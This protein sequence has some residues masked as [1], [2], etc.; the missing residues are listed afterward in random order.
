MRGIKYR[1][2]YFELRALE[3]NCPKQDDKENYHANECRPL[4]VYS[5]AKQFPISKVSL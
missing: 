2:R 4:K 5:P 1:K 3:G